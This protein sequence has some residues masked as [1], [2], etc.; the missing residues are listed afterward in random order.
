GLGDCA[1]ANNVDRSAA[2]K[3]KDAHAPRP[4]LLVGPDELFAGSLKPRRHHPA[5][6]VPNATEPLPIPGIAPEYP[7]LDQLAYQQTV[8]HF[9]IPSS[10][11]PTGR[12]EFD[13]S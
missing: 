4:A 13:I 2:Q 7:I 10:A 9:D 12:S 1:F 11:C 8:R 5:I 3:V 6:A